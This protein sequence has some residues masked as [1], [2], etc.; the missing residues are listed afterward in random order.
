MSRASSS[1]RAVAPKRPTLRLRKPPTLPTLTP[2]LTPTLPPFAPPTRPA[3]F[4][5]V[6]EEALEA[7]KPGFESV[8]P[9]VARGKLPPMPL[10][11]MLGACDADAWLEETEIRPADPDSSVPG[12]TEVKSAL[13]FKRSSPIPASDLFE[14]TTNRMD[15]RSLLRQAALMPVGEETAPTL[16]S[17]PGS[18]NHAAHARATMQVSPHDLEHVRHLSETLERDSVPVLQLVDSVSLSQDELV[19]DELVED[20]EEPETLSELGDSAVLTPPAHALPPQPRRPEVS[21]PGLQGF[22]GNEDWGVVPGRSISD[23]VHIRDA[24]RPLVASVTGET[25]WLGDVRQVVP[26]AQENKPVPPLDVSFADDLSLIPDLRPDSM[27]ARAVGMVPMVST[28]PMANVVGMAPMMPMAKVAVITAS[29]FAPVNATTKLRTPQPFVPHV[30]THPSFPVQTAHGLAMPG[31]HAF[32][33]QYR[34]PVGLPHD[35]GQV[36]LAA[37][38]RSGDKGGWA[39]PLLFVAVLLAAVCGGYFVLGPH[40]SE[41]APLAAPTPVVTALAPV[42]TAPAPVETALPVVP[43]AAPVVMS[44]PPAMPA[45]PAVMPA[46]VL[47]VVQ[48]PEKKPA[49]GRT[50]PKAAAPKKAP[51]AAA[52]A[53]EDE[54]P[55]PSPAPAPA[56]VAEPSVPSVQGLGDVLNG[57]L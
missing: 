28:L 45:P 36:S 48:A 51:K 25:P 34:Q 17:N 22:R 11:P 38:V 57:A 33:G 12:I 13:A 41:P 40:T 42:V 3:R 23:E 49:L 43:S 15:R 55:K 4:N 35:S 32:Q 30:S 37:D 19:E 7:T 53:P 44:A 29:G 1:P 31:P 9:T 5:S 10:V 16:Q 52:K 6:V 47:P 46:N 54:G 2:T 39:A 50:A 56:P 21:D 20:E 24:G 8:P 27:E 14:A 26:F 18:L